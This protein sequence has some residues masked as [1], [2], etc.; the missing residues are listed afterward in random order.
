MTQLR[1]K[2]P[3]ALTAPDARGKRAPQFST[4]EWSVPVVKADL[5]EKQICPHCGA[6]F[7]DLGKR[8]AVCP[9]CQTAFDPSDESIRPKRVRT[10][11]AAVPADLEADED[12]DVEAKDA[13]AEDEDGDGAEDA[14]ELDEVVEDPVDSDEEEDEPAEAHAT[15][16]D[17]PD[18]FSE[19]DGDLVDDDLADGD[20]DA[21][22]LEDEEDGFVDEELPGGE[23]DGEE[24]S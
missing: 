10:R 12:E 9:K 19:D 20:D 4:D 5:G 6:K 2:A 14:P 3:R 17:L 11:A 18:G 24:K 21:V 1:E 13:D 15:A 7:Y 16:G 23:D 8:P 22:L